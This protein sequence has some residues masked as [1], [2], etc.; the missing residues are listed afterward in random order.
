MLCFDDLLWVELSKEY[1]IFIYKYNIRLSLSVSFRSLSRLV[2]VANGCTLPSQLLCEKLLFLCSC[3]HSHSFMFVNAAANLRNHLDS[4]ASAKHLVTR[5]KVYSKCH[6]EW[7][8]KEATPPVPFV[9][10]S[11]TQC[12]TDCTHTHILTLKHTFA[13]SVP[14][15]RCLLLLFWLLITLSGLV[16]LCVCL[17]CASSKEGGAAGSSEREKQRSCDRKVRWEVRFG[18]FVLEL[19]YPKDYLCFVG[20][21]RCLFCGP[22]A[23]QNCSA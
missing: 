6:T 16:E 12:E 18:C 23:G 14:S 13:V 7:F 21:R 1:F 15:C 3:S 5:E 8:D 22:P 17:L 4:C 20:S 11:Y 10:Y 2:L 9:S 19:E